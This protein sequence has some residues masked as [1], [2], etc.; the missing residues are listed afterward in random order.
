MLL[1]PSRS[2]KASWP[3]AHDK[4][5]NLH[6]QSRRPEGLALALALGSDKWPRESSVASIKQQHLLWQV[7]HTDCGH[8]ALFPSS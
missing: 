6:A 8:D 1:E 5:C 7:W 4:H 2:S 3:R